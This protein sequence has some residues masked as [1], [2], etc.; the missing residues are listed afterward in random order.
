[1]KIYVFT[2]INFVEK[3]ILFVVYSFIY[4][5]LFITFYILLKP[6]LNALPFFFIF[7]YPFVLIYFFCFN[8]INRF[9]LSE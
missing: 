6:I 2:F 8:F 7:S 3:K 4:K 1:M 9:D 5:I